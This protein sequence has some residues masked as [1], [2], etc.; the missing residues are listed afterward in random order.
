V[1]PPVHELRVPVSD[2]AAGLRVDRFLTDYLAEQEDGA[3]ALSRTRVQ[4]LIERELV[5]VEGQPA[6]AGNRLRGG[7]WLTVRLPEP[8]PIALIPEPMALTVIFEDRDVIAIAKPA[9]LVVHPGAGRDTGTLVHGLLAHCRDLSGIGGALRPGI[10][11]RLDR[12]T[13]G[14]IIAA[15]ND[16]AHE[17]LSRQFAERRVVKRYVAFVIGV[18]RPARDT[19]D[20]L[21]GRH[22][23]DRKR[24]SSRVREGRR[25]ITTYEVTRAA[26]GVARLAVLLG[27]GRTHQ[28]RVHLADRGHPIAGDPLYGVAVLPRLVAPPVRAPV[29]AL[30]RQALHAATL[31]L[32][33]PV[34]GAPLVLTAPLPPDLEAIDRALASVAE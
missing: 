4:K 12:G 22:P 32:A 33:H 5:L 30:T 27:T 9:D 26:F 1:P 21:Y 23:S 19:I 7:E 34:S 20:T 13:S 6:R 3:L 11:H 17:G 18:P 29:N 28:I 2:E 31:E 15:K 10:V 16:R 25:A 24:F 14:V 8:E